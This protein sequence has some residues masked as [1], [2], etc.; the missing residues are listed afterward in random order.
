MKRLMKL[1]ALVVLMA[2]ILVQTSLA[3]AG[4]DHNHG[5]PH[6]QS[7][8]HDHEGHVHVNGLSECMIVVGG[9]SHC[10]IGLELGFHPIANMELSGHLMT[11][12]AF[13]DNSL[14]P[15]G[16]LVGE[17]TYYFR[18]VKGGGVGLYFFTRLE[19][20]LEVVG[21][22]EIELALNMPISV[23]LRLQAGQF[24]LFLDSGMIV[25]MPL[26][27][28]PGEAAGTAGFFIRVAVAY[29]SGH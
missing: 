6:R 7:R 10:N 16:E 3:M 8:G 14:L 18:L 12:V 24:A 29:G 13:E 2:L 27:P 26:N 19:L 17:L 23:G 4:G 22:E 25:S 11:G 20:G 1:A 15:V 21:E 9:H 28:S 5:R